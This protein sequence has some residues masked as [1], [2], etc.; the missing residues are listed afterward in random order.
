MINDIAGLELDED[1]D[2]AKIGMRPACLPDQPL[3]YYLEYT[4]SASGFGRTETSP[5]LG[6]N[7]LMVL[8]NLKIWDK[9][10]K[11]KQ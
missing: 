2:F 6:S 5:Q 8:H 10:P 7:Q 3:S 11:T 4:S 1:V 9:C